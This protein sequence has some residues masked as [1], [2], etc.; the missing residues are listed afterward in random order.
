MR[1]FNYSDLEGIQDIL[2][3]IA[4]IINLAEVE[5]RDGST[6]PHFN[7]VAQFNGIERILELFRRAPNNQIR[8]FSAACMGILYRKQA[9]SDPT[10]RREIIVQCRSCIY[11]K[12]VFVEMLGQQALY[13][14]SQSP[15]ESKDLASLCIGYLYSGRRI[16]NRQ[17]QRDIILHLIRLYRNYD[18]IKRTYV[19]IA[20]LDLALESN[21]KQAMMD[22][23]F[24]PLSLV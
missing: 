17:M 6:H 7:L 23:G 5:S 8:N 18:G 1:M 2:E 9:I 14:L 21:N 24:D 20:L 12:D 10:M 11:D 13:C 16:P 15:N 3:G 19:R 4:Y 22:I